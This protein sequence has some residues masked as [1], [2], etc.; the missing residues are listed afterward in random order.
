LD[1]GTSYIASK[2]GAT[3]PTTDTTTPP[4]ADDSKDSTPMSKTTKTVLIVGGVA[5]VGLI[6]YAIAKGK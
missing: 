1:S 6:I 5:V 2:L 3:V 4:S